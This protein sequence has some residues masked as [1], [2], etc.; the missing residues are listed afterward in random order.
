[1]T[2]TYRL[3]LQAGFGFDE[4]ATVAEQLR[5]LGISHVYTSPYLQAAAGSTHGYDVIDH[6]QVNVE[7][8]GWDGHARMIKTLADLG[9]GH[10][11]DVVPNH[12]A[13][14]DRRNRWWWDVLEH[15]P[16]SRFASYFDVEWRSPDAFY[17]DQVLAP[18]LG[19][20]YG[21]VLEAGDLVL[22]RE[23]TTFTVSYFD[24]TY[25]VAPP[26]LAPLLLEASLACNQ[27]M[28]T[29]CADHLARLAGPAPGDRAAAERRERDWT[30]LRSL[31]EQ[32]LLDDQC[33]AAVDDV[34]ARVNADTGR[35]HELLEAQNYRLAHWRT[36]SEELDYRR[37]F[38]ITTLAG[39]RTEDEE[40][41]AAIHRLVLSWARRGQVDG[42]RIDHPDGLADPAGYFRRLADAAPAAWVGAEKILEP[43]EALP[44]WP[45]AGT[46]GY[47][48]AR[49]LGAV[50]VD[51]AGEGPLTELYRNFTDV[52]EDFPTIVD[53]AKRE[54]LQRVLAADLTRLTEQFRAVCHRHLR[55]R[56][57]T[58]GELRQALLETLVAFDVYRTYTV[59]DG[60]DAQDAAVLAEA[61]GAAAAAAPELDPDA[62][63]FLGAILRREVA[64]PEAAEM[65][66]RFQQL[67][68]PVMAKGVEDTAFYRYHRLV[69]LNEVGGDPARFGTTVE[70]LHQHNAHMAEAW[71]STML[72]TSTH[73]TKRS[74]DVR[75]R[76][77]LLS[78]VPT[79]WREAV[80]RWSALN[81]RHRRGGFPD[82]NTEY[83]LYQ[84]LVGA[85]PLPLDRALA[86]VEKTA[87]EAKQHTSWLDPNAAYEDAL[88]HFVTAILAD[89]EFVAELAALADDLARP[90]RVTALAQLTV[91]LASPGV[92]DFYQGSELWTGELVDPDNRRPVDFATRAA[93]L[94]DLLAGG[95]DAALSEAGWAS[96]AA[97]LWVTWKG[98][99]LRR[100]RPA[101]FVGGSYQPLWARGPAAGH[102]VGIAR[103]VAG[104]EA[105]VVALAPRLVIGLERSGGW[106]ETAVALPE[107]TWHDVISGRTTSGGEAALADLLSTCPVAILARELPPGSGVGPATEGRA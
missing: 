3:Q 79:R 100:E 10:V 15:G 26:S 59:P 76:I 6:D 56:D 81:E 73:D 67:S 51:P 45:I 61:L 97:K 46:T 36:A 50:F 69:C 77:A 94:D 58:R 102:L 107:G 70:E 16:A 74:E 93:M 47:D 14:G 20:H 21:R 64:G 90:A 49:V 22:R 85:H 98:L 40:V 38:D 4:A 54:I 8:G 71:P 101:T 68:G 83:L 62:L 92:P 84:T 11:V 32:A 60:V 29:F 48:F 57:L 80:T 23:G 33:T 103:G 13:I 53:H 66:R 37:F 24:H 75:V 99:L 41:F 95:A 63:A 35:L 52:T 31:L 28:L 89:P 18:V 30:V 86:Y 88:A 2:A 106:R 7:L 105:D 39:L 25:P 87:R 82:R 55:Y 78:E 72:A 91:K 104:A 43:G 19:D 1:L 9:L 17:Q 34:V 5:E 27:P 44:P 42:L 12:M 96:G 65:A